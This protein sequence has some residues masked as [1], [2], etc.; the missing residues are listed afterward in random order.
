MAVFFGLLANSGLGDAEMHS[1]P[2]RNCRSSTGFVQLTIETELFGIHDF[3]DV[4]TSH[5]KR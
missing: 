4:H 1:S 5:M 2:W 3:S